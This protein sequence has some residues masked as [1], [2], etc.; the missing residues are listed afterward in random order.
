MALISF[1]WI[2][3]CVPTMDV[4][5]EYFETFLLSCGLSVALLI[6]IVIGAGKVT[7]PMVF[8]VCAI[9]LTSIMLGSDISARVKLPLID[10]FNSAFSIV[11]GYSALSLLHLVVTVV[12]YTSA[13][14]AIIIDVFVLILL[15]IALTIKTE[16]YINHFDYPLIIKSLIIDI[17][18]LMMISLFTSL[19][20]HETIVS[21]RYAYDSG[22]FHAWVDFFLHASEVTYLRDYS[23]FGHQSLY[24]SDYTQPLY[25]HASYALAAVFSF[26]SGETSLASATFFWLPAGIILFGYAV[27]G[28]ACTLAG[29]FA[30]YVSVLAM[31]ALPDGS[32]YSVKNGFFGFHWLLQISP[33]SGYALALIFIALS[34]YVIECERLKTGTWYLIAT[35][36]VLTSAFRV[37]IAILSIIMFAMLGILS[38]KPS[39]ALNSIVILL[40]F[41]LLGAC[42]IYLL[43]GIAFAPHF[44]TGKIRTS[45]LFDIV[46][47]HAPSTYF[48]T[49][50]RWTKDTNVVARISIGFCLLLYS[51][52]G[53]ILPL[54]FLV[55]GLSIR[56]RYLWKI[57]SIPFILLLAYFVLINVMPSPDY[58][59]K[60]EYLHRP[61]LL[62]YAVSL[63]M[64]TVW[65]IDLCKRYSSMYYKY[66]Q[67]IYFI[68][69]SFVGSTIIIWNLS[70]NIQQSSLSWGVI[71]ANTPVSKDIFNA[72][73]Y[74]KTN[75]MPGERV[76]SSDKDPLAIVV[77]LTER[78]AF[79][80][81][82]DLFKNMQNDAGVIYASNSSKTISLGDLENYDQLINFSKQSKVRWYLA[83]NSQTIYTKQHFLENIAYQSGNI[84]VFDLK[85]TFLQK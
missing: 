1:S 3:S 85:N 47:S 25:H 40:I 65:L 42:L 34:L 38:W 19:W 51:S 4:K 73:H 79:L 55:A 26:V 48:E 20:V 77:A 71:L 58:I 24:L 67:S 52:L 56:S 44:I 64:L 18:V 22:V 78:Q 72:T 36:V 16:R 76:F 8:I 81:R 17:S 2:K 13:Q 32:M 12:T 69:F 35:I 10:G 27:Y 70:I 29:K 6:P 43:E 62:V 49:Y 21:E 41:S 63:S 75:S 74:I 84:I 33:S 57:N 7:V 80:S 59:G 30:G 61:F 50:K 23:S 39:K 11:V 68:V 14:Q 45:E 60:T 9:S 37:H 46:H 15:H 53:I 5:Q 83:M 28:F 54:M 31:F 82:E 66:I